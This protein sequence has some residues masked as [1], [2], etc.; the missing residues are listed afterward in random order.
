MA[1]IGSLP[2]EI[3][4]E[5]VTFVA[6][7]SFNPP[8]SL[9]TVS[10]GWRDTILY[11]SP[12]AW[13]ALTIVCGIEANIPLV[14]TIERSIRYSGA[15]PLFISLDLEGVLDQPIPILHPSSSILQNKYR[16]RELDIYDAEPWNLWNLVHFWP[17]NHLLRLRIFQRQ[18]TMPLELLEFPL[19]QRNIPQAPKLYSL[20]LEGCKMDDGPASAIPSL[21]ELYMS[22]CAVS[23][24]GLADIFK[25][26]PN[27][28]RLTLKH[29]L[30][31]LGEE[32]TVE[33]SLHE[34]LELQIVSCGVSARKFRDALKMCP[35]LRTLSF[36]HIN[37]S[38]FTSEPLGSAIA[39]DKNRDETVTA[40]HMRQLELS[41]SRS[42]RL[43]QAIITPSL[44]R[45]SLRCLDVDGD[46]L[47]IIS[48]FISHNSTNLQYLG[49]TLHAETFH[50]ALALPNMSRLVTLY[51]HLGN[52]G[53][54]P[55][56]MMKH[57]S[58]LEFNLQ[59]RPPLDNRH[60]WEEISKERAMFD[61]SYYRTEDVCAIEGKRREP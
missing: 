32:F 19:F 38:R 4:S 34:L 33:S 56:D 10:R 60:I 11:H 58:L 53:Y 37:D 36:R 39:I 59:I 29:M 44:T 21:R 2:T 46:L 8:F 14:S 41:S 30:D 23:G 52:I 31:G 35:N 47:A 6:H 50:M 12:L 45:L 16:I 9:L 54:H 5:I 28:Q 18:F 57:T 17:A 24:E 15:A 3:L 1:T 48:E 20:V 27:L 22:S 26:C 42:I 13:A 51:V 49:L 40:N 55:R 61:I 7:E 43:L 25:K